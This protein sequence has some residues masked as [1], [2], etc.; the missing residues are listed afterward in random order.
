MKLELLKKKRKKRKEKRKRKQNKLGEQRLKQMLTDNVVV[1]ETST[2]RG[3]SL[4]QRNVR[5][6]KH[7]ICCDFTASF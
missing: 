3:N 4:E 1:K 6:T 2:I 7:E 5:K